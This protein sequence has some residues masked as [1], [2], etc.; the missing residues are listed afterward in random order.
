MKARLDGIYS[1]DL[2]EGPPQ[3]PGDSSNCWIV[4]QAD[5]GPVG[6]SGADTFTFYVCTHKR[7]EQILESEGWQFGRHLLIVER[8][9]WKVVEAAIRRLVEDHEEADWNALAA[10]LGQYGQWEFADHVDTSV[11]AR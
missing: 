3:L 4:V 5:I 1:I 9:D 8:F 2:P 6:R 7:M 11:S 10:K